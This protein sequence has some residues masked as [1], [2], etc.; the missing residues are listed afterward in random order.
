MPHLKCYEQK[1]KSNYCGHCVLDSIMV[2]INAMCQ[3]YKEKEEETKDDAKY[4]YEFARDMGY[5]AN[6]D[7]HPIQCA[8][9]RCRYQ[10]SGICHHTH[11]RVDSKVQGPL[12]VS[13]DP[14]Y[15]EDK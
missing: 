11:V 7:S 9:T 14:R 4:E 2:G 1:C 15:I 6:M 10:E 8:N 3:S 5:A 13:F 12:C